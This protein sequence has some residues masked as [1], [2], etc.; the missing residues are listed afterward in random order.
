MS[1]FEATQRAALSRIAAAAT[2]DAVEAL[3]VELLGKQGSI[4][5]LLKTLGAMSPEQRQSE[6]PKIHGLRESVTEALSA[7][8]AE[9]EGAALEARLAS[10]RIDLTLPAP[11][12]QRGSV[13]PISQVMD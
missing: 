7:R 2:P 13:H 8:K 5:S 10:E 9:M 1:E 6:G 12:G 4:S 3:R 11:E